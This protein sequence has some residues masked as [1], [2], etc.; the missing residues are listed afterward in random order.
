[1]HP[2]EFIALNQ[3][4]LFHPQLIATLQEV[5]NSFE[6]RLAAIAA[7]CDVILDGYY[8]PQE[9]R[10]I[11]GKLVERLRAKNTLTLQ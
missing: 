2:P 7:Y 10:D 3:E 11:A 4:I 5:P 8:G 1:M 6:E 9:L